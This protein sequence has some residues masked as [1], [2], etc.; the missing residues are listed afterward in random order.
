MTVVNKNCTGQD[1]LVDNGEKDLNS[2][3][4]WPD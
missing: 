2:T 1:I 4:V 3:F